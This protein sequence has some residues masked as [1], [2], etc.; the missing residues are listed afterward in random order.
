MNIIRLYRN[1]YTGL[2]PEVWLLTLITLINRTGSMVLPFLSLY[3][4]T[5]EGYS[6]ALTGIIMMAYGLGSFMG[7]WIGGIL[8]DKLGAFRLQFWSLF[9][10]SFAFLSLMFLHQPWLIALGLFVT[11]TLA[12]AFRPASMASI[13]IL[14]DPDKRARAVGL[15]RL[16]VNLGFALGPAAGGFIAYQFGYSWIFVI[17]GATCLLAAVFFL[18]IFRKQIAAE[19]K[20]EVEEEENPQDRPHMRQVF[21]DQPYLL[22]LGLLF[23]YSLIF[24]QYFNAFPVYLKSKMGLFENDIGFLMAFNGLLIAVVEMPLIHLLERQNH[25][26]MIAMGSLLVGL[27]FAC[28]LIGPYFWVPWL[29][30]FLFTIGEVLSLPFCTTVVLDRSPERLRGRYMALYGMTFSLAHIIAPAAG[31]ALADLAGFSLLWGLMGIGML[32][33]AW[34]YL[35]LRY[36]F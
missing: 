20:K 15:M 9:I 30:T 21:K 36:R 28:L 7:N 17:D 4:N 32:L 25:L 1:S 34:A 24:M 23:I 14:A 2:K 29:S 16:A 11:S 12:D 6:L 22:F 13:G 27:S 33:T 19:G 5:V 3:L 26:K 18:L 10:S 8:T 31:L 35:G